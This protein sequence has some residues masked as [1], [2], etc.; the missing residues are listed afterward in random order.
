M[1]GFSSKGCR[2]QRLI[3]AS[4]K[5]SFRWSYAILHLIQQFLRRHLSP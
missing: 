2:C 1:P 5:L 3:R 4:H